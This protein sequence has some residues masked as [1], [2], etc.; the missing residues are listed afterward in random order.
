MDRVAVDEIVALKA[1]VASL[2]LQNENLEIRLAAANDKIV[3]LQQFCKGETA[4]RRA[5]DALLKETRMSLE[6][7]HQSRR[8]L[9][10]ITDQYQEEAEKFRKELMHRGA[11]DPRKPKP[12]C[13]TAFAAL[14]RSSF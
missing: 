12:E 14:I 8:T 11:D 4:L 7:S 13:D 6:D 9:G 2:K 1:E 10:K 3:S 5:G